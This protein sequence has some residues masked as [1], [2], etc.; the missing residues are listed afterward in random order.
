MRA[1]HAKRAIELLREDG[2]HRLMVGSKSFLTG[3]LE[4]FIP[5]GTYRWFRFQ[6]WKNDFHN[7]RRYDAPPDPYRAIE[8]RPREIDH[9]VGRLKTRNG[10]RPVVKV[11]WRGLGRTKAGAWDRSSYRKRVDD[12]YIIKGIKQ[13][14]EHG[15]DWKETA[16]YD[17]LSSNYRDRE[18]RKEKGIEDFETYFTRRIERYEQLFS[19]IQLHGY[20]SNHDGSRLD[21][22]CTQPVR[23]RL[24]V[25]VTI[26]R[27]GDIYFFEGNHRFGIARVLDL[28]IPA[29][30]VCRH[31]RWQTLRDEISN[32]GLSAVNDSSLRSHPD[33]TDILP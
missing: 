4:T 12:I 10:K 7:R 1:Q 13:R 22:G 31:H 18:V 25:L 30:V 33:L 29:H 9:K 2:F 14:Y 3:K 32:N 26:G 24:E 8:I 5:Y 11:K 20:R 16:Y 15:M 6:T 28:K 27:N 21:P 23:D 19:D 17:Y